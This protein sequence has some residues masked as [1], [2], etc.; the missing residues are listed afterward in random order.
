VIALDVRLEDDRIHIGDRLVISCQ[1]TLR[2]PDD[3]RTYPLPP[4]LGRFPIRRCEDFRDQLPRAWSGDFLVPIYRREA[5]WLGFEGASWKPNAVKVGVGRVDAVAG[6]A[7]SDRLTKSPQNYLVIPEQPWLDGINAG[8]ARVR[9]FVA[10]PL[11]Q[12]LSVEA[13]VTGTERWGGLQMMA[14][15]PKAGRFP[16]EA[17]PQPAGIEVFQEMSMSKPMGIAAGGMM[18]QKIYP[19]PY[20]IDAWDPEQ[21][22]TVFIHLIAAGE[23]SAITGEQ[24]P[25]TPVDAAAYTSAGFPWFDVYDEQ[26]D[27][28]AAADVLARIKSLRDLEQH[29][30]DTSIDIA[31][32]QIRRLYP[33]K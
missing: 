7:W 11:G 24:M 3:G 28:V 13:Q 21:R 31:E 14:F 27:D 25:S 22:A 4:G 15:E 26:K 30:A 29:D 5:L 32:A 9:Q 16:D 8:A 10:V 18:R 20:G 23:Y 17:P 19:D 6:E 1:R 12:G 2:I 33:R